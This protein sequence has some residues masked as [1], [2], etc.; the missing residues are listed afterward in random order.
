M[1]F[2]RAVLDERRGTRASANQTAGRL[3][4]G[5]VREGYQTLAFSRSRVG[6]EL[7]ARSAKASL[8]S[9]G[10]QGGSFAAC[11]GPDGSQPGDGAAAQVAAYRGGYLTGER[12]ELKE[13]FSSG[14][15]R[16][17]AA[18]NALELGIDIGG[19]DAVVV[20]GFP[21]TIASL[22]QQAGRAGRQAGLAVC[23][24]VAPAAA[25]L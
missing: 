6:V 1:L 8:R 15:L 21:G 4:A 23:D 20:N 9:G 18:T 3:L 2:D 24:A 13:R 17:I 12:R 22:W 16:G 25:V 11:G 14:E 19:L 7:V 10:F 5:L